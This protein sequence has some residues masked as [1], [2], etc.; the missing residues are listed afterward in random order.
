MDSESESPASLG[1]R[2]H[3]GNGVPAFTFALTVADS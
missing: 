3:G 1:T 2:R